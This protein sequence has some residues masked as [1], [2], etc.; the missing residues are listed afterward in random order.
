MLVICLLT[1]VVGGLVF[2][3]GLRNVR[4]TVTEQMAELRSALVRRS[5]SASPRDY[6]RFPGEANQGRVN[7]VNR[8]LEDANAG[9]ER[10]SLNDLSNE[11]DDPQWGAAD[12]ADSGLGRSRF[13]LS[14]NQSG[15]GQDQTGFG[16]DE[17]SS[18]QNGLAFAPPR[19]GVRPT[20]AETTPRMDRGFGQPRRLEGTSSQLPG[21]EGEEHVADSRSFRQ[22]SAKTVGFDLNGSGR[23]RAGDTRGSAREGGAESKWTRTFP[24]AEEG[25]VTRSATSSLFGPICIC[26]RRVLR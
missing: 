1:S 26:N 11:Y 18:R 10:D 8:G 24:A 21:F 22:G 16:R 25:K 19:R 17:S 4:R 2:F 12:V 3:F 7:G 14:R 9:R 23:V 15:F 5:R 20:N 13:G 6:R